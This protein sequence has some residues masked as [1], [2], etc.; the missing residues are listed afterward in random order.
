MAQPTAEAT[1][2]GIG[3]IDI[4]DACRIEIGLA[5][6][7]LEPE[8]LETRI[9][10]ATPQLAPEAPESLISDLA[11]DASIEI[12][13]ITMFPCA[14]ADSRVEAAFQARQVSPPVRQ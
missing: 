6:H 4:D 5:P 1:A 2:T 8:S 10:A 13:P 3:D 12:E 11:S 14:F 7:Q 9:L